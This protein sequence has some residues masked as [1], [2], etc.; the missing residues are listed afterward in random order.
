VILLDTHALVW[1]VSDPKRIPRD[2][3]RAIE[4]S[5]RKEEPLGAS[6]FSVWEIA[7]L[8]SCGRLRLNTDLDHWLDAVEGIRMLAFHPVD[9]R[10]ARRSVSLRLATP[11]PA[12][13][14][15][16][17]TAIEHNATLVTGDAKLRSF[18]LVKTVWD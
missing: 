17:S 6:A 1:W 14:I 2:A 3:T 8:A 11:D 13:R 10:I 5:L 15:I 16:V 9:T 7:M 18:S 4:K 12:D